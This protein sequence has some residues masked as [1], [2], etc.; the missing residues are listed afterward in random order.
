MA[1]WLKELGYAKFILQSDG[2][3]SLVAFRDAVREKYFLEAAP[4]AVELVMCRVSPVLRW[5]HTTKYIIYVLA[6]EL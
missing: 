6:T 4:G 5:P 3:P 1:S 2:E